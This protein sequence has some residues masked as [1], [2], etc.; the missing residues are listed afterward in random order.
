MKKTIVTTALAT[1]IAVIWIAYGFSIMANSSAP[2]CHIISAP[3][4]NGGSFSLLIILTITL[5]IA[6][7]AI[8]FKH[9][10]LFILLSC[11]FGI[12]LVNSF[13]FP[14]MYLRLKIQNNTNNALKIQSINISS[15]VTLS[16]TLGPHKTGYIILGEG[17]NRE[18]LEKDLFILIGY[19]PE[20]NIL[21]SKCLTGE[22]IF[23]LDV[24]IIARKEIQDDS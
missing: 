9:K 17:E 3:L 4:G 15:S 10:V 6:E 22:D 14:S 13:L 11:G 2:M 20:G 7:C 12:L 19:T 23:N 16:R 18:I 5:L 8:I 21:Y 1:A 24:L